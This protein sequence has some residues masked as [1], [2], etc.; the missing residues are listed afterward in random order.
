MFNRCTHE[1]KILSEHTTES[2]FETAVNALSG[3]TSDRI[4]IPHQMCSAAR[5]FIQVVACD[6]CGELKRFVEHI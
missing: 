5:M 4:S 6:K 3:R 2:R 1:W